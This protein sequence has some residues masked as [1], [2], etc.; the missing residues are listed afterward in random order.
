MV[1]GPRSRSVCQSARHWRICTRPPGL[2]RKGAGSAAPG[3]PTGNAIAAMSPKRSI[4]VRRFAVTSAHSSRKP[5]WSALWTARTVTLATDGVIVKGVVMSWGRSVIVGGGAPAN[6]DSASMGPRPATDATATGAGPSWARA[7]PAAQSRASSASR[8]RM[9]TSGG[10]VAEGAVRPV[11]EGAQDGRL[12][13]GNADDLGPLLV[14]A[15]REVALAPEAV[16]D[17]RRVP[18]HGERGEEILVV[19][20]LPVGRDGV[21]DPVAEHLA[22]EGRGHV[23]RRHVVDVRLESE[24]GVERLRPLAHV[25]EEVDRG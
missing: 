13:E 6:A 16:H 19:R 4:P 7:A 24:L 9:A 2:P 11:L 25:H 8:L 14:E 3:A 12:V 20:E 15:Q 18:E 21:L 10:V 23:D 17:E 1:S 5:A 22:Q